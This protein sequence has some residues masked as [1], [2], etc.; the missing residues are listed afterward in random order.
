[1]QKEFTTINKD[2]KT[3]WEPGLPA[4]VTARRQHRPQKG[5]PVTDE[6]PVSCDLRVTLKL[7]GSGKTEWLERALKAMPSGKAKVQDVFNIITHPKFASGV[8]ERYGKKMLQVVAENMD[9]FSDKQRL[10]LSRCKLAEVFQPGGSGEGKEEASEESLE[11]VKAKKKKRSPSPRAAPKR[12][13][14]PK[15]GRGR[16]SDS[17]KPDT[18]NM[19]PAEKDEFDRQ[20][21]ER[22]RKQDEDKRRAEAEKKALQDREAKRKAKLGA[23]FQIEDDDEAASARAQLASKLGGK[24]EELPSLAVSRASGGRDADPRF[25]EAMG[26]DK[27][28]QEAHKILRSAAGS[29]RLGTASRSRSRSRRRRRERSPSMSRDRGGR[30]PPNVRSSGSYRSPTPDGRARG[31][32]RAARK[33]KMIASL[34]GIR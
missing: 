34:M 27:L 14:S 22:M 11:P 33:A 29:G 1:M 4:T 30:R 6:A 13:S 20:W 28:L 10:T 31:Q 5:A 17:G 3:V 25:V 2:G 23:A 15:E 16:S 19:T 7:P 21:E 12:P 18:S 32:A 26:G 24:K 9:L 8:A